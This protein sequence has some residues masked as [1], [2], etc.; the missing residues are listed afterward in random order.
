MH[1]M[2]PKLTLMS[3]SVAIRLN[4]AQAIQNHS[5]HSKAFETL[6]LEFLGC[7]KKPNLNF[8]CMEIIYK[9]LWETFARI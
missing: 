1:V 5:K 4:P 9:E 7:H 3:Y 8:E 2:P 6:S